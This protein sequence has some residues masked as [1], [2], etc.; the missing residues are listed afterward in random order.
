MKEKACSQRA[1][2]RIT[3]GE[4]LALNG[5]RTVL[6]FRESRAPNDKVQVVQQN[7]GRLPPQC[8]RESCR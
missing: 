2:V 7:N 6:V 5:L 1:A 3:V 4:P 8:L